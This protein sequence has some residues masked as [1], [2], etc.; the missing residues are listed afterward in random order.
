MS[1][2]DYTNIFKNLATSLKID[3]GLYGNYKKIAG[4]KVLYITLL[5]I[6]AKPA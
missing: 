1:F 4:K 6:V 5:P 2:V 3:I